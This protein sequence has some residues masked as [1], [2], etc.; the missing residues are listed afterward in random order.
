MVIS[1]EEWCAVVPRRVRVLRERIAEAAS[2]SGRKGADVALV[3]VTK[4]WPVEAMR[5]A[6][7]ADVDALGENRIQEVQEKALQWQGERRVPWI[8]IGHLQRNKA[9]KALELFDAIHSLDSI[10]LGETLERLC[11]EEQRT[12]R[13][14]VEVNVSGEEA[15]HGVAP[16]EAEALLSFLRDQC[17][18][19]QVE[20]LMTVG[21][22]TE[23][24]KSVRGAFELLRNLRHALEGHCGI[25]LPVLSM[26]MSGDFLWAVE[27]GSTMVRV[28]SAIFGSRRGAGD[29]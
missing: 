1:F 21:P 25:S 7:Q 3:A 12:C 23:D 2:R 9:R 8:L 16:T 5:A 14:L 26:G 22:L 15:K 11:A 24:E 10:R 20:G 29:V 27:E 18:R 19:V 6:E 4:T 28:G 13:V 17:P